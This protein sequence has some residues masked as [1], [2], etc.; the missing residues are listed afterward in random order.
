MRMSE[1][2]DLGVREN[3]P[4]HQIVLEVAFNSAPERFLD[5]AAPSLTPGFKFR[6]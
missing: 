1:D 3:Q 5:Q 2:T 6:R 4:A